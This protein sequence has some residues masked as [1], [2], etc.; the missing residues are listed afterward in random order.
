MRRFPV[1]RQVL[2]LGLAR[3]TGSMGN[4]LLVIIIPLYVASL[5]LGTGGLPRVALI[6]ILI[7][8]YGL[9]SAMTQPLAGRLSDWL[10]RR[11]PFLLFGLLAYAAATFS[12]SLIADYTGLAVL[13][14]IQGVALAAV[15]SGSISLMADI[16]MPETRGGSM[17]IYNTFQG[18]GFVVGPLIAGPVQVYWGFNPAFYIATAVGLGSAVIVYLGIAEPRIKEIAVEQDPVGSSFAPNRA[19]G[20][21][22]VMGLVFLITA[23]CMSMMSTLQNEFNAR[24]DQTAV[25]FSFA[26]SVM[27]LARLITQI[28]LGRLSDFI[29]RKKLILGGLLFLAPATV[30]LGYV[31][32]TGQLV[33]A[34]ALQGVATAGIAV[35][36]FALAADKAQKGR[37]GAQMSLITMS[38]G[39]GL[40]L[41]PLVAGWLAGYL[42]FE[43]PFY[44]GGALCLL[45]AYLVVARLR[46]TRLEQKGR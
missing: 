26:F 27:V 45:G 2:I 1:P 10:G 13:R 19:S 38:F 8:L 42:S 23:L 25:G 46:E 7:S 5:P 44:L 11:K 29:G 43:S 31:G 32:S 39:L 21:F 6:G 4:S 3:M 9:I 22:L 16:T 14:A 30:A 12:Y 40:A 34:R 33:L 18:M 37:T 17:G 36:T 20:E 28:P 15:I 35:P 41:G 24:L